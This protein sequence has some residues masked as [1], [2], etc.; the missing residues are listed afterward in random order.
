[1]NIK[2]VAILLAV[3]LAGAIANTAQAQVRSSIYS[4]FGVGDVLDNN[5]GMNRALGGTGIAFQSGRSVNY[6]NPASY[7]GMPQNCL[8][9][10]MG[11]YGTFNRSE[12]SDAFRTDRRVDFGYWAASTNCA[13]WWALCV[14]YLPYS[15]IKY[16]I[17]S[18]SVVG[19]ELTSFEKT[20]T[21]TGGLSRAYLGNSFAFSGGL[22][23]GFNASYILGTITRTEGA[24]SSSVITEYELKSKRNVHAFYLD[25]GLQYTISHGDWSYVVGAVYGAGKQLA[26][27][28]SLM[29]TSDG[30]T[31]FLDASNQLG[32]GIPQN[33]GIGVS[34]K[35]DDIR[36]GFDYRWANWSK[37]HI[38]ESVFNAKDSHRFSLGVEY[39]IRQQ[40]GWLNGVSVRAGSYF[41]NSYMEIQNTRINSMGAT[42]GVGIPFSVISLNMSLEY[43]QEGTLTK[44]LVSSRYLVFYLNV[45]LREFWNFLLETD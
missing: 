23:G 34:V 25:Y 20:F 12:T 6:L 22:T 41:N 40:E 43:G 1:M 35:R 11:L 27:T 31:T 36:A 33:V 5:L 13:E 28:D 29:L 45:S 3:L 8:T 15:S 39:T 16:K 38:S 7:L 2:G 32:L 18:S 21:G 9:M 17:K 30:A 42:L 19:G 24:S 26:T 4:M 44:G 37:V 10:E 14:G